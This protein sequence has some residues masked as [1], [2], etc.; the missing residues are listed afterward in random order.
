MLSL[1]KKC[2]AADEKSA[3]QAERDLVTNS[4]PVL[5]YVPDCWPDGAQREVCGW[6]VRTGRY[7]R[8]GYYPHA[9]F[10]P[11]CALQQHSSEAWFPEYIV[12]VC[13]CTTPRSLGH[14]RVDNGAQGGSDQ[15]RPRL[16][17]LSPTVVDRLHVLDSVSSSDPLRLALCPQLQLTSSWTHQAD[18]K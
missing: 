13:D 15:L 14:L 2:T 9:I 1:E 10:T 17:W 8:L 11:L 6:Q 3:L 12:Y 4:P 5:A 7:K 16:C 18:I